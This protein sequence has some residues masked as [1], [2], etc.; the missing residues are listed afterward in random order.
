M[1]IKEILSQYR[2]DFKAIYECEHC[3]HTCEGAGYDDEYFHHHVV[4]DME[5]PNCG[6]KAAENYRPLSTLYPEEYQ[7]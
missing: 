6:K 4:P 7:I 1:R 2:R 3:G 5:C